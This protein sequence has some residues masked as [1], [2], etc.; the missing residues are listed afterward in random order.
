MLLISLGYQLI[1]FGNLLLSRPTPCLQLPVRHLPRSRFPGQLVRPELPLR[2]L[3]IF[4]L[5][6]FSHKA[7]DFQQQDQSLAQSELKGLGLQASGQR[8]SLRAG[9]LAQIG[10]SSWESDRGSTWSCEPQGLLIHRWHTAPLS[11]SS[12]WV[13]FKIQTA[14]HIHFPPRRRREL[15]AWERVSPCPLRCSNGGF[16]IGF[17]CNPALRHRSFLCVGVVGS[18][19]GRWQKGVCGYGHYEAGRR[20]AVGH[21]RWFSSRGD[22]GGWYRGRESHGGPLKGYDSSGSAIGRRSNHTHWQQH[23]FWWSIWTWPSWTGF[24]RWRTRR[25]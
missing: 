14:Y 16:S 6:S 1:L 24:E 20:L 19:G 23:L 7:I 5:V 2:L 21:P 10:Q 17:G 18:R 13:V 12:W 25:P 22:S 3:L 9:Q 15:T 11:T 4:A 8:Q